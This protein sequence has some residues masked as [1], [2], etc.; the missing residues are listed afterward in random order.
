VNKI[1]SSQFRLGADVSASAGPVG[2]GREVDTDAATMKSEVLS[3][4]RSRGLFAGAELGGA[5]VAQEEDA[6]RVLYGGRAPDLRA[7]LD[8][9]VATRDEA[10]RRLVEAVRDTLR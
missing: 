1:A 9:K 5:V 7:L 4:S 6:T 2:R 10:S 8:G 3:Y